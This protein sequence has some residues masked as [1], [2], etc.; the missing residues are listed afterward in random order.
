MK[1]PL[2]EAVFVLADQFKIFLYKPQRSYSCSFIKI[3]N[4][5][6]NKISSR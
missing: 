6:E 1:L 5:T 2:F 3:D 4:P